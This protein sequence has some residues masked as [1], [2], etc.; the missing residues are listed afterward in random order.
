MI[1]P[2]AIAHAIHN[3]VDIS[4]CMIGYDDM[5][6]GTIEGAVE[7]FIADMQDD[8]CMILDMP[9]GIKALSRES[10]PELCAH[11]L[12]VG[13]DYVPE[14]TVI[15]MCQTIIKFMRFDARFIADTDDGQS[16]FHVRL[17][18]EVSD[19]LSPVSV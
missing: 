8:L 16:V 7:D 9:E 10:A 18:I 17:T 19:F 6:I 1:I 2:L 15:D 3:D 14:K 4:I 5:D 12:S 11:I 13:F